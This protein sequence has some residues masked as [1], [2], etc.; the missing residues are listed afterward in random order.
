MKRVKRRGY[1]REKIDIDEDKERI[2]KIEGK[3]KDRNEVRG[4]RER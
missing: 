1:N 3:E 2:R 4:K